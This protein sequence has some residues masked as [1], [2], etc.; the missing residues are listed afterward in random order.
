[1][2]HG[3]VANQWLLATALF[4][5]LATVHTWSLAT[6]PAHLSFL[7]DDEWLNAWALA[8]IAHQ[9]PRDPV[10]LFDA[11]MFHPHSDALVYTEPLIVP[12]LMA[13]PIHWLGG[14]ALLAH[15]LLVFAGLTLTALATYWLV[16]SWTGDYR[17]GLLSGALFALSSFSGSRRE[18]RVLG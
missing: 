10:H 15:N 13:A 6:G 17:A 7:N 11:N 9:I 5:A 3:T 12:G 8:W 14:S 1:M 18:I 4:L 16:R 2:L